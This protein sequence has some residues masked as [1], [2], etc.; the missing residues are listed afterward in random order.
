MEEQIIISTISFRG[1]KEDLDRMN[2]IRNKLPP[3]YKR[4]SNTN[5]IKFALK[6]TEM[7]YQ[8]KSE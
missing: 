2:V 3:S 5:V 1:L 6:F 7:N 8:P 4:K